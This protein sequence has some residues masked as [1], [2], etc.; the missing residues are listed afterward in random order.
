ML[1]EAYGRRGRVPAMNMLSVDGR[2]TGRGLASIIGGLVLSVI[3]GLLLGNVSVAVST[4]DA[5]VVTIGAILLL[6]GVLLVLLGIAY[7]FG[8]DGSSWP[9]AT[10]RAILALL[11]LVAGFAVVPA[12]WVRSMRLLGPEWAKQLALLVYVVGAFLGIGRLLLRDR[13]R[14]EKP[15]VKGVSVYGRTLV[16]R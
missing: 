7:A 16:K 1:S 3:G 15:V 11:A 5:L 12:L 6:A 2:H 8:G 14:S 10:L 4:L 9:T 13:T